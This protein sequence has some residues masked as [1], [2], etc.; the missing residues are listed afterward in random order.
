MKPDRARPPRPHFKDRLC[1]ETILQDPLATLD[2]VA[3]VD[4]RRLCFRKH[5]SLYVVILV[6]WSPDWSDRWVAHAS[7]WRPHK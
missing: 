4:K 3:L 7:F 2:T 5:K 1:P 6:M